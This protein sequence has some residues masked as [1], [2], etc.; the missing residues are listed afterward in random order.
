[1]VSQIR[2]VLDF[3]VGYR[4]EVEV[5]EPRYAGEVGE[6]ETKVGVRRP[7]P[8]EPD[9]IHPRQHHDQEFGA[10]WLQGGANAEEAF[11]E[12]HF[13]LAFELV[14]PLAGAKLFF[15][16]GFHDDVVH[17]GC[18]LA[19]SKK[20]GRSL[21]DPPRW[22]LKS[23]RIWACLLLYEALRFGTVLAYNPQVVG[24]WLEFAYVQTDLCSGAIVAKGAQELTVVA[25]Y[26]E[27]NG[28]FTSLH[29]T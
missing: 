11:V 14:P 20:R 15:G 23:V 25:E 17:V 29:T 4:Q 27:V 28:A 8:G 12:G 6:L 18:W 21:V 5:G 2:E 7:R 16:G 26:G 10:G 22:K 19:E 3:C 24:P 9:L 13:P 1:M